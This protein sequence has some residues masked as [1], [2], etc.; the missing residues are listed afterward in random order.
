MATVNPKVSIL[1]PI[2]NVENYIERC[3][4]SLFEQTYSNVE[5]VFVNDCTPDHSI[6]VLNR[7][8]SRYSRRAGE[9]NIISHDM[10]RG[11]AAS[12]NTAL[13]N[14]TGDFVLC[15]DSDDYIEPNTVE[16]LV[17]QQLCTNSDIVSGMA[18]KHTN[19]G[20]TLMHHPHYKTKEEMVIDMMQPTINHTIWR[21][22]IRKSLFDD[23]HVRAK[24][25]VNCGEDCWTMT[26]LAYFASSFSFVDEVVYHYDCT[27]EGSYMANSGKQINRKKVKDDVAT[28]DLIID[29]FKDKE[30]VYFEE[31][32]RMATKYYVLVLG[33]A[34]LAGESEIYDEMLK[35][36]NGVDEKY[37]GDIGW[38]KRYKRFVSKNRCLLKT[39]LSILRTYY[40]LLSFKAR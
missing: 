40:K 25:G 24:E 13:D 11:L 38:D 33:N 16:L 9:I 30:E 34:A 18:L 19:D 10:N 27:R 2:Y 6:D 32:N 21:R 15:V 39:K 17:N 8:I 31:A 12:R 26:Q 23:Y 4:V 29:F 14:C 36:L 3:A 37:W 1:V 7:V 35:R 20:E 28:A 5:Y 22:L